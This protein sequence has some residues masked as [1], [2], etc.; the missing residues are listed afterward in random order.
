MRELAYIQKISSLS[1]I[2]GADAIE[3]AEVLGWE[4]VV[5]SS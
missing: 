4:L 2:A 5:K 3:K 1:P